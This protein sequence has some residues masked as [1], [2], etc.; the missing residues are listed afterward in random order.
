MI[1]YLNKSTNSCMAQWIVVLLLS[2]MVGGVQIPPGADVCVMN[3]DICTPGYGCHLYI[4]LYP[5]LSS[6]IVHNSSNSTSFA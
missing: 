5:L 6:I 3:T 2:Q 1:E 4:Y